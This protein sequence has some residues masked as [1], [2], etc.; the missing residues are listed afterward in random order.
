MLKFLKFVFCINEKDLQWSK[1]HIEEFAVLM[2]PLIF[3]LSCDFTSFYK[4]ESLNVY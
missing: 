2:E 3:E 1:I 4:E